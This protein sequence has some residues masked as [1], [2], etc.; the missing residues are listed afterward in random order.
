M[1]WFRS[2][3]VACECEKM[4]YSSMVPPRENFK[5][6]WVGVVW[7]EFVSTSINLATTLK[8]YGHSKPLC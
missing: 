3:V 2:R 1:L 8:I 6:E 4:Y 7:V 5:V